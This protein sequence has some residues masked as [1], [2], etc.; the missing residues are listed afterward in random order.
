MLTVTSVLERTVRLFGDR[1]AVRDD[2]RD[3]TWADIVDRVSRAASVLRSKGV[4]PGSRYGI[5]ARNSFRLAELIYAGYWMGAV[6]VPINFRFA[7]P[8]IAYV[9]ENAECK[10]VIVDAPFLEFFDHSDLEPW[11]KRLLLLTALERDV[12]CEFYESLLAGAATSDMR[13]AIPEDEAILLYTG[14]TT[15][16]AKGVPLSHLNIVSNALQLA[17]E[18]RPRTEDVYL[19]VAPM[20][21]SADL[22]A[23]PWIMA[24]ASHVYLPKFSGKSVLQAIQDF[25]VTVTL[26]TPTMLVRTMQEAEFDRFDISSLREIIYGSSPMAVEWIKS[27]LRQFRDAELIQS[28][29]LTETSPILTVLSMSDH[30]RAMEAGNEKLLA[31]VGRQL[32]TVDLRIVDDEGHDVST[33]EAGEI[34]VRGPNVTKGYLKRATAT[35]ESFKNGWFYTGDI[36]RLDED[37]YLFL[38]DRKKDMII[39][40]GEIVYSAEVEAVL[41]QHTKVHE[42]AVIGV[43]DETY[44]EALLAVVVPA[45]GET[46]E[47]QELINHCRGKIGGYKIPRRYVFVDQLPKSAVDKVLKTE[48]R[49]T[50]KGKE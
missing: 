48:L 36:G 32:P 7:P 9:L 22:L 18:F 46:L 6:P 12:P 19:H 39:T 13:D 43:P 31:S 24:G 27:T 38:L 1:V 3:L 2:E 23:T 44:G 50:Y 16:R 47:A 4:T 33:G 21:H 11:S 28:Y 37:G 15:G 41:H 45:P 14:G 10:L 5:L 34:V 8:E 20:F 25:G 49:Q 35:R 17:T 30:L 29:G 26:M 42:C 40:G